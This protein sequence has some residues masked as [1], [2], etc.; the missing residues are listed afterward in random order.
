MANFLL[1]LGNFRLQRGARRLH[2]VFF[3]LDFVLRLA[4][5]QQIGLDFFLLG[6]VAFERF[7]QRLLFFREL[8]V[9][10][11]DLLL[12]ADPLGFLARKFLGQAQRARPRRGHG[13]P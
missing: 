9:A 2:R 8:P 5:D 1:G 7:V 4:G 10:L 3:L 12:E 11:G 13:L 6:G